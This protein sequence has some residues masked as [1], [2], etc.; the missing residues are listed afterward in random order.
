MQATQRRVHAGVVRRLLDE[1]YRF[2]FFQAVRMLE[3]WFGQDVVRYAGERIVF[4]NT[5]SLTFAPSELERATPYGGDGAP[6]DSDEARDAAIEAR[7]LARIDLVPAFFGMLGGQ[8][9]LPLHY[10]ED[11]IAREQLRRDRAARAYLDVFTH[12]ATALFYEAWKKYRL[13]FHYELDQDERYLPLLLAIAGLGHRPTRGA[14]Q[15]GTGT[16]IDEALG[17]YAL[18]VRQR[19]MSAAYLERVLAD[20]FRVHVR[21]EQ[22]VGKWYEVPPSHLSQLGYA[23]VTLGATALAGER[24]WQRDMRLRLVVGPLSKRDY[25]RLLPA[26]PHAVALERMLSLVGGAVFEYEVVLVLARSE[27]GPARLGGGA[28]LGW[29][30]FVCTRESERD[31]D[32]ARYEVHVSDDREEGGNLHEVPDL[33]YEEI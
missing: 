9:A 1:P 26:A 17:G 13:P 18:P 33:E 27:V 5:L 24:V 23:N 30:A 2:Q 28:R 7:S 8:G 32:D 21:V 20:Y 29:D 25:E 16:L 3:M 31:R 12:R 11:L 19:P 10:T 4:R 6:V 22:F 14:L 15:Q